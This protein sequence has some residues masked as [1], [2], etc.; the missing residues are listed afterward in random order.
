M[1]RPEISSN[2]C[3]GGIQLGYFDGDS[4]HELLNALDGL[5]AATRRANEN[6]RER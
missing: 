2:H 3:G 6:F 5:L 1:S 4:F